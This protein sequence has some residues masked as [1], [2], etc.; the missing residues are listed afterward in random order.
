[1]KGF[2]L[3]C[4]VFTFCITGISSAQEKIV[5]AGTGDSQDMLRTLASAFEKVNPGQ[6]VEV[7]YS[8][9]TSGGIKALIEG[10]C[11]FARVARLPDEKEK[12]YNLNYGVF[13]YSP[14]VIAVNSAVK[15]IDNIT[16]EQIVGI[17]SG[18]ITSWEELGGEQQKIYVAQREAGD[19]SRS[20]FEKN[21]P[22]WKEIKN[23]AGEVIYSTPEM[24]STLDRYK[25][26]IGYLPISVARSKDLII[27]KVN[28]VYP[29][30]ENIKNASYKL[31][32]PFG[33]IWKGELKGTA[34][35]FLDF[36]L[37]PKGQGIILENGGAPV[38]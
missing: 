17:F 12:A 15:G 4:I 37:S 27:L 34:R 11:D 9:G 20:L 23:F 3:L 22:G 5:I 30:V 10:K 38:K 26:T 13:A 28:G 14:I 24:A 36:I 2:V 18:A 29:S 1:M 19:S 25:Y 35:A 7:P 32:V 6:K 8:I 21:I 31:V 33:L 16:Y